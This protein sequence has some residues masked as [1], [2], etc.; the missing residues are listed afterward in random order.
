MG[1]LQNRHRTFAPERVAHRVLAVPAFDQ[2]GQLAHP[3]RPQAG[4][5]AVGV[6]AEHRTDLKVLLL[7]NQRLMAVGDHL[8]VGAEWP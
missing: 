4:S 5:L 7:C 6:V 1:A 2:P 8:R 3:F